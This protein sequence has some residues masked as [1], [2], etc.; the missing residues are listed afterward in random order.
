MRY[1]L[2]GSVIMLTIALEV[3]LIMHHPF[4]SVLSFGMRIV[5]D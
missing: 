4:I 1:L 3:R 5:Q 2:L